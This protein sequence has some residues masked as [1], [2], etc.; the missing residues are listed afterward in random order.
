MKVFCCFTPAHEI[1]FS[2]YFQPSLPSDFEVHSTLLDLKGAGDFY[3]KEFLEC[4]R[5][6]IDLIV[7]SMEENDGQVILW[8]D[9]DII[10]LDGTAADLEATYEASG[11]DILFQTESPKTPEVNTGFI[12]CR[13]SPAVA[14]FFRNVGARL[15]ADPGKNEQ[16]IVNEMLAEGIAL[17]WGKLPVKYYARTHGWPAP[18]DIFIY[19][20]NY[21]AGKDGIGQK[22][23]QFRELHAVRRYGLP[24]KLWFGLKKVP[25]K[26][27]NYLKA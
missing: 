21:T 25:K 9:V 6:K 22:I 8:S 11:K 15:A 1:L 14:D 12:V 13:A 18:A 5:R 19:H 23:R 17:S 4:I 16:A 26:L 27:R 2:G 20:A 24:A 7:R 3:S 10:F